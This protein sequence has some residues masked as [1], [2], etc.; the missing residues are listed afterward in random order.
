MRFLAVTDFHSVY[1][2]VPEILG[3]AGAVDGTL[4]AGDLTEFGPSEKAKELIDM[5]PRPILAV[6]G[7]CDPR[8]IVELLR[9][10]DANLHEN[11]IRLG[12]VTFIG[13]GGSNPTPFGTPFE[14]QE[15]EI[16]SALERLL[17]DVKGPAILIS[18]APPKGCRD[19]IPSGAHVGSEA[20]A[21]MGS[22]FKAIVCGHIHE[23]RGISRMGETIVVNP[24]VA[25]AG[26]AALLE[27]DESGNV[28]VELI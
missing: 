26:N 14:L 9:R 4:L 10:E 24:G 28:K 22:R 16:K 1:D 17:N 23:D 18:H 12:G 21:Q 13:V 7:N 20:I 3:K 5:L 27:A 8:D 6:P 19:R 2:R 15:A 25:S 11:K